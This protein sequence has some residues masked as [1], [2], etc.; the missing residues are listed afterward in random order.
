MKTSP[1]ATGTG[2]PLIKALLNLNRYQTTD[3]N[4]IISPLVKVVI[5][6]KNSPDTGIQVLNALRTHGL[7]ITRSAFTSGE[8][9]A[10][11][12]AD[13][14]VDLFLTTNH[15]DVKKSPMPACVPVPF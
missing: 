6:S 9:V 1:L 2:Y 3:E 15:D 4:G 13:F 14:N 8:S 10:E 11:Y 7:P 12:V 5:M